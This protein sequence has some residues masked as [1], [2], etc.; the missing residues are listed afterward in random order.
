MASDNP[1]KTAAWQAQDAAPPPVSRQVWLLRV[2][3]LV[4]LVVPLSTLAMIFGLYHNVPW[5]DH[6]SLFYANRFHDG[7]TIANLFRFH[8]EHQ[9][10]FTKLLI[11]CDYV[12]L[13]GSNV[14]PYAA[15]TLTILAICGFYCWIFKNFGHFSSR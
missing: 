12:L 7:L 3:L 9:I 14:L 2:L 8:N 4:L 15:T 1:Q 13:H 5:G 6:I 10:V 11:Y